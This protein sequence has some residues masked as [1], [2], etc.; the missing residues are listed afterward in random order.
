MPL[1]F[2]PDTAGIR[3]ILETHLDGPYRFIHHAL[4][5][6]VRVGPAVADVPLTVRH[7]PGLR[8]H[9]GRD[10][11]LSGL[12]DT[13]DCAVLL[14]G[15]DGVA[16]VEVPEA[17]RAR[18]Q[19][20]LDRLSPSTTVAPPTSASKGRKAIMSRSCAI[21][22]HPKLGAIDAALDQGRRV[23]VVATQYRVEKPAL[24]Q[25]LAHGACVN[26]GAEPM[27]PVHPARL[28]AAPVSPLGHRS[29]SERLQH[30]RKAASIQ[31]LADEPPPIHPMKLFQQGWHLAKDDRRLREDM[32][33]W[34]NEQLQ[35]EEMEYVE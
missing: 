3:H 19:H 4:I 29:P 31:A 28:H 25:H 1:D 8:L 16:L 12:H 34:L 35:A 20:A 17:Q 33:T 21:C 27:P 30:D 18:A 26:A 7:G 9:G 15:I 23:G 6:Y 2:T 10:R 22:Q 11:R 24:V 14:S 5:P 32:V 13:L